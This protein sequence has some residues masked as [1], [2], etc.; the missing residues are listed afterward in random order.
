[1]RGIEVDPLL[2]AGACVATDLAPGVH[3]CIEVDDTGCGMHLDVQSRLFDPF[4]TTKAAGHGLGLA[5]VLGVAKSHHGTIFLRTAPGE[6][7]TFR[8]VLPL[9]EG[10]EGSESVAEEALER[11]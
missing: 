10:R 3:A 1:T 4:F 5:A 2:L 7:S 11:A 6:G 9:D 8:V